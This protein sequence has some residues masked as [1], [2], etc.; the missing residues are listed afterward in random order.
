MLRLIK[1]TFQKLRILSNSS[2]ISG[3]G[4][5]PSEIADNEKLL[6]NIF[7]PFNVDEKKLTLKTNTFRPPS[8]TDEISVNRLNYT[9]IDFCR[10]L[11]FENNSGSNLRKFFG[12]ALITKV[13]VI[14]NFATVAASPIIDKN[15][16]HADIKIGYVMVSGEQPPAEIAERISKLTKKAILY[17]D[18]NPQ[19]DRWEGTAI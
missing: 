11:A 19:S 10:N 3:F 18:P 1:K 6:R 16:F 5:V 8:G 13:A 7:S 17:V 12:F 2:N 15:P 9:S 4:G 14:E